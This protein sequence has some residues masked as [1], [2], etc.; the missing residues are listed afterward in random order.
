M[1]DLPGPGLEPVSPVLA[2]GF[3]TTMPPRKPCFQ[4]LTIEHNAAVKV[5]YK[6]SCGRTILFLFD[7]CLKVGLLELVFNSVRYCDINSEWLCHS[8]FHQ[9]RMRAVIASSTRGVVSIFNSSYS[10][11]VSCYLIMVLVSF[12]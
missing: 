8:A 9:Q 1:W 12:P 7:K 11:G 10:S 2:G 5:W 6:S 3:L 4:F